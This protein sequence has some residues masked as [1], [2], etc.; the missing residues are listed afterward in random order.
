MCLI[1]RK[2]LNFWG[3][4]ASI[5]GMPLALALYWATPTG[6]GGDTVRVNS[7]NQQGGITANTIN[8]TTQPGALQP[9]PLQPGLS[10]KALAV[11]DKGMLALTLKKY[12]DIVQ[13][14]RTMYTRCNPAEPAY[15]DWCRSVRSQLEHETAYFNKLCRD[16]EVPRGAYGCP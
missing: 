12:S 10:N 14:Y 15:V 3:T 11:P 2:K 13:E 6:A 1:N 7:S 5:V 8:I 16:N 4:V 9:V